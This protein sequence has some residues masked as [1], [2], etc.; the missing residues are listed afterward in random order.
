MICDICGNDT[1]RLRRVT[2]Q[3]G[4]GKHAF[5]IENVPVVTCHTCGER[6]LTADTLQEIERI[7]HHG[8]ELA[9]P[10]TMPIARYEKKIA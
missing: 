2:R 4:R 6:Y 5:L 8:R 7:R 1:A 9:S 10:K 3:I